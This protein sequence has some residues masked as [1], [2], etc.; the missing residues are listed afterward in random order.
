MVLAL[1]TVM[2]CLTG[3]QEDLAHKKSVAQLNQS[4]AALMQQGNYAGAVARLESAYVL[5]PNSA[6]VLYNLAMAYQHAGQVEQSVAHLEQFIEKFSGDERYW[7]A[8]QSLAVL[9]Q[10]MGALTM[11]PKEGEEPSSDEDAEAA[12]NQPPKSEA[13]AKN[14]YLKSLVVLKEL[15]AHTK[16]D[17]QKKLITDNIEH[18]ESILTGKPRGPQVGH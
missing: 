2:V 7:P 14:Y 16:D 3:C 6:P 18:I 9:Y 11:P 5:V 12:K 15:H 4:A 13:T 10:Q 8:K 17:G 1:L